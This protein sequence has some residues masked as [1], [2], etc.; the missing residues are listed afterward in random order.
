MDHFIATKTVP[1]RGPT[2]PVVIAVEH[3]NGGDTGAAP[4]TAPEAA[5]KAQLTLRGS[6]LGASLVDVAPLFSAANLTGGGDWRLTS[7]SPLHSLGFE[8]LAMPIC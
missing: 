8:P 4:D 7:D 1:T 2:A 5:G 3:S 6:D